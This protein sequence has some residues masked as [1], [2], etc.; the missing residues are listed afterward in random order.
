MNFYKFVNQS[1]IDANPIPSFSH[2]WGV[3]N[4]LRYSNDIKLL[5]YLNK[6]DYHKMTS[7]FKK[8]NILWNDKFTPDIHPHP[9]DL[10]CA[11]IFLSH[12][13]FINKKK[14][15]TDCF[16]ICHKRFQKFA[17][18]MRKFYSS[19]IH[20]DRLYAEQRYLYGNKK[21]RCLSQIIS[22][23]T[24]SIL[25]N[26]YL[27]KETEKTNS[28]CEF[29]TMSCFFLQCLGI[30]VPLTSDIRIDL[31]NNTRKL[32]TLNDGGTSFPD[33]SI[34]SNQK[35][36][37]M[38]K[39]IMLKYWSPYLKDKRAVGK[40]PSDK[41]KLNTENIIYIDENISTDKICDTVIDIEKKLLGIQSKN[42]Q[43]FNPEFFYNV[44]RLAEWKCMYP[45]LPWD[46]LSRLFFANETKD[47]WIHD[48][49]YLNKLYTMVET[50]PK[51]IWNL[52]FEWRITFYFLTKIKNV[53]MRDLWDKII[54]G[55]K[56]YIPQPLH[57]LKIVKHYYGQLLS[58]LF[59]KN[60][61]P[62]FSQKNNSVDHLFTDFACIYNSIKESFR[63]RLL[64]HANWMSAET[65]VRALRKLDK[66]KWKVG[67]FDLETVSDNVLHKYVPPLSLSRKNFFKNLL[68]LNLWR[69]NV[70]YSQHLKE[71]MENEWYMHSF[72]VNAYYSPEYNE[73][74]FPVGILQ[75][76]FFSSNY[77]LPKNLGRIG[78]IISHELV[79]AFD[80]YGSLYDEDG[81]MNQWWCE[82]DRQSFNK[83]IQKIIEIY[84]NLSIDENKVDGTLTCPENIADITAV[85]IAF[86]SLENFLKRQNKIFNTFDSLNTPNSNIN[87]VNQ[88]LKKF[89]VYCARTLCT[90]HTTAFTKLLLKSDPHSPSEF[91]I[92]IPLY[93]FKPFLR[94]FS[95]QKSEKNFF[96][97][98]K[99][100]FDDIQNT[101][102]IEIY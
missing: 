20:T 40:T 53:E 29:F 77:M 64:N 13:K 33:I 95:V 4:K 98:K 55:V 97:K 10:A 59:M 26:K 27:V 93:H 15:N 74:V 51:K 3:F 39:K 22:L 70:I 2:S 8:N 37:Q 48:P 12:L 41:K 24:E 6:K 60:D 30:D 49:T 87:S 82:K 1:Y 99:D 31:K 84:S 92:N 5:R 100:T 66:M 17:Q 47:V 63:E 46:S 57:R 71:R 83:K 56:E 68:M 44:R 50:Y 94:L 62:F 21:N 101:D 16:L 36:V 75:E 81:N 67:G 54:K 86:T 90:Y 85:R 79:H 23:V 43:K 78:L 73:M 9:Q 14:K 102:D 89:F 69:T 18:D 88:S 72:D 96:L 80:N 61:A 52:Y 58:H 38:L 28:S 65:K 34:Y 25:N 76:P 35:A 19:I 7:Y 91:R 32:L 11:D 42:S 45:D